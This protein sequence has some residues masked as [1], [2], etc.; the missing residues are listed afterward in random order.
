MERY[1]IFF[2]FCALFGIAYLAVIGPVSSLIPRYSWHLS[3]SSLPSSE[4]GGSNVQ[5]GVSD[6]IQV[7]VTRNRWYGKI[8]EENK[9]EFVYLF[10]F[11]KLPLKI[12]N[13]SFLWLHAIVFIVLIGLPI[14]ISII[15]KRRFNGYDR[16]A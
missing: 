11:L 1:V 2:V 12:G 6:D 3:V 9:V 15:D 5:L 7:Y 4:T 10:G 13:F 16:M 8:I 14:M